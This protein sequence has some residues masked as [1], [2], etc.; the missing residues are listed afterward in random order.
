MSAE[1][2]VAVVVEYSMYTEQGEER[3][4]GDAQQV[5]M[6]PGKCAP[7]IPS[8]QTAPQTFRNELV[9]KHTTQS[10]H[11]FQQQQIVF[12]YARSVTMLV[13]SFFGF[14]N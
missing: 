6:N 2:V 7:G 8:N 9:A 14:Q 1:V 5:P 10:N 4:A 11:Y 3:A 13:F 12:C